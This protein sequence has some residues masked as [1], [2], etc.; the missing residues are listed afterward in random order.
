MSEEPHLHP[1]ALAEVLDRTAQIYRS[2]FFVFF[3]I[4]VIPAG[5]VFVFA[6]AFFAFITW[7]GSNDR[8]NGSAGTVI[9]LIFVSLMILLVV[10]VSLGATALGAAAMT[11]AAGRSFL[12]EKITIREAYKGAWKRGW[13]YVWLYMLVVLVVAVV[14][15]VGFVLSALGIDPLISWGSRAGLGDLRLLVNGVAV[16]FFGA[17]AAFCLW[18]LLRLCLSFP[19][20]VVEQLTAWKALKRSNALSYGTKAR[21]VLLYLMG[22]VLGYVLALGLTIPA[23]V[24]LALIP[25]LQ[26]AQHSQTLGVIF[27]FVTWASY[28]AVKAFTKP[29][30]G[31]A[32]TLFY[33][34]QRIRN[35][36]FDIEWMMRH[37]GMA[38]DAPPAPQAAAFAEPGIEPEVKA[39]PETAVIDDQASHAEGP[40]V[41]PPQTGALA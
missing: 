17:L 40:P 29:V 36:G 32:L 6:S 18:M 16:L 26:G 7:F 27:L 21:I 9:A 38:I 15:M 25:A 4:G 33:F 41:P 3:G 11:A 12:G 5:T 13:R 10:P 8:V 37:A 30:Y 35:E 24:I 28:F 19:V 23:F 14:P 31:I 39:Q 20:S 22:A 2:R 1:M 34:D